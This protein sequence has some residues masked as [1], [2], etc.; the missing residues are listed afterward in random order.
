M[1]DSFRNKGIGRKLFRAVTERLLRTGMRSMLVWV[2]ADDPSRRFY[3]AL[4]GQPLGDVR[5]VEIGGQRLDEM[6][7]GWDEIR[8]LNSRVLKLPMG[9]VRR[10]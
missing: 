5:R 3:E 9:F 6:V 10:C 4:G 7:Y 2:L 1:L 8:D